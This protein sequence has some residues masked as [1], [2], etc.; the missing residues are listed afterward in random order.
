MTVPEIRKIARSLG[1]KTGKLR[2]AGFT[3]VY[4]L[5]GGLSAWRSENYPLEKKGSSR[6]G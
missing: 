6:K 1:V 3:Q 4:N 5:K 2:K